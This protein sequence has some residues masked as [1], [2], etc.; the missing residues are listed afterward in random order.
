MKNTPFQ[1]VTVGAAV[2]AILGGFSLASYAPVSHAAEA[3]EDELAEITVT[4][5]R[6]LRR[7]NEANSPLVTIDAEALESKSGLNIESYLNQLP[8]Y[9]PA[10]TPTFEG[11]N[12]DV[13]ISSVNSVGIAS[14]SLRGFGPNRSLVLVDGRRAIPTNALMVVDVN[15]IPSSMI[16]SA[17]IISGG[18]SAT[19]GADAMGGVSNFLLRRDFQGL[20][21]DLQYGVTDVS[22]NEEL[23]ASAILGT[24]FADNRGNIVFAAEYYDRKGAFDK[25]RRF[26]TDSYRDPTVGGNFIGFVMGA[27]GWNMLF[28]PANAATLGAV[29]GR[30]ANGVFGFNSGGVF[31]G[32]RFNEGGRI[33]I[34]T[35]DNISTWNGPPIDDFT[36]SRVNAYNGAF[37]TTGALNAAGQP[38]CP[39]GPQLIQQLKY[40]ETEGYTSSPQTRYS[41]MGSADYDITDKLHFMSSARF[42]QSVTKTFLAGTNASFG[43]EATVPYNATVDSPVVLPGTLVGGVAVN[44]TNP[45]TVAAALNPATAALYR[46]PSFIPTGTAG[47]QHPVPVSMA[48]L[49]NSRATAPTTSGWV[50]ETWPLD[51]FGRRATENVNEAWQVETGLTY[52]L[53][54]KDWTAEAYFSHGE[55]STYN[56]AFG[57][58]SLA[59]WRGEIAAA[60]YGRNSALQSNLTNNGPGASPGFGSVPVRCTSGFY[61]TIFDG[62]AVPSADCAYA[63][64]APL[65]TR[66]QNQQDIFEL[67]LQGGLFELPAGEVRSAAGYQQRRNASQFNP[68]ILQSTASFT[69]QV[70]G[71][72]PTGYLRKQTIAKDVW[73][74]VLVPVLADLPFLKKFELEIGGRHSSYSSTDSTDTYKINA[75]VQINDWLRFR[76]GYN[77]ATRAPNLG[78]LYLPY[79]QIFTGGGVYGDPC[80]VLSNSP[81]GAGGAIPNPFPGGQASV[82]ASGQTAAGAQ[83]AYLICRAQMGA[84][85]AA[86]F[87]GPTQAPPAAGGGGFAWINQI[88]NPNLKSEKADTYTAGVVFRS[89]FEH[90]L[91][92]RITTTIDYYKISID[93]AILPYSIDY[94]RFLCYGAVP[95]TNA[96]E[97][98]AQ[99]AST[100][101]QALPRNQA[102]GGSLT[103]LVSYDNQATVRTSGIDFTL[104]WT[105]DLADMGLASLP[106]SLNL[107]VTGT[108]LQSYKT[109]QSPAGYDPVIE[110][111]GSLGPVLQSF[112]A[113]A[114]DYRLFTNLSYNLPSF[115]VNLRWRHLPEVGVAGLATQNAIIRNNAAV[116]AGAVG[117]RLSYT[118]TTALNVAQF[119]QFDLSAYWTI[120]GSLS[121]RFG[122]DNV[123]DTQPSSTSRNA[124][125][126]YDYGSSALVN[127]QRLAAVCQGAAG[128]QNPAGYSLPNSGAGTTNGGFYDVLGRRYFVALKASF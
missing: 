84:S 68:D 56:V 15:S 19:Y 24:K 125:R 116:A 26:Y 75:N 97:A 62:D 65:Q 11:T 32:L 124:G 85:A 128:C 82:L 41:F 13:Q 58:N 59:R 110:W 101:C 21:T 73:A 108:W 6:I 91:V 77:K 8:A 5:S 71:V 69:D 51:S 53:P 60:D 50:L 45:A 61:D 79:Q 14:I 36:Y 87:Y 12:S 109:K 10:A 34:P 48:I 25:N 104:N 105:A 57:N 99:A 106:G 114:Y 7:D 72:Y 49:L 33:F 80:G 115:G 31:N 37:C 17:E 81:F 30:P 18:A 98:A 20:E 9:N 90:A 78:E 94:A 93:D 1:R 35:G 70:I 76:G 121:V 46:N 102:L 123:L 44:W 43:W 63:V 120:N 39:A 126:P 86:V 40:N 103:T 83:S 122:V 88:G 89:P 118:P 27:N 92:S 74:E 54:I 55:S 52:D 67:N 4:G 22:D 95:V 111:K 23:R 3:E 112:N 117:T 119:D 38:T 66:T 47:A 29:T 16:K 2:A 96:T 107:N 42:A 127:A 28:N 113:G 64:M 100:A